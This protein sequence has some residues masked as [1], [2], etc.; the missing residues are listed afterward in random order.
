MF[1]KD[2]LRQA[3][4]T[5]RKGGVILYPTDTVWGLG[6]DA[7]NEKAVSRIYEIKRRSES[8][9][10][11]LLVDSVAR[12]QNYVVD[13]P[14]IAFDL[15][16]VAVSPTTIIYDKA[17]NLPQNLVA[18]DGSIAIRVTSELFSNALCAAVHVPLVST[19]ANVS[20]EPAPGCFNEISHEIID[21]VDYVVKFRQDDVAKSKPSSIIKL[22]ASGQVRII[23]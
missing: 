4:Q 8:K 16:D 20:G 22:G 5:I 6:C 12:V 10:L 19:S 23:R 18:D 1:D 2:D 3:L 14:D 9:A 11:I 13:F 17:K 21:A 7:T 15:L